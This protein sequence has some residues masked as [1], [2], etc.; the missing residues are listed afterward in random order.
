[1]AINLTKSTNTMSCDASPHH[2]LPTSVFHLFVGVAGIQS[3]AFP[4]PTIL[5]PIRAKEI[6]L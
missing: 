1:M 5:K 6:E 4:P 2:D 3:L